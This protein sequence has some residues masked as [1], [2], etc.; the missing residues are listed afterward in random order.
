MRR[1]PEKNGHD[2]GASA[3]NCREARHG[4]LGGAM[5]WSDNPWRD[6]ALV[7]CEQV[8]NAGYPET[9]PTEN[10]EP[11]GEYSLAGDILKSA[12]LRRQT[13]LLYH[14][15]SHTGN[16]GRGVSRWLVCLFI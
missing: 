14:H 2:H 4:A 15:D 7:T 8:G 9:G 12:S 13:L 1:G 10:L 6:P 16:E 3:G 11:A 5:P